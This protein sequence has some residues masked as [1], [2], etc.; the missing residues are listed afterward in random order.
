MRHIAP[1]RVASSHR[2]RIVAVMIGGAI[3]AISLTCVLN[4]AEYVSGIPWPEPKVVNPG[5][6]ADRPATPS[7]CLTAETSRN[8]WAATTGSS[9]TATPSPPST[10]FTP[11]GPSAI[12]NSTS[13]GRPRKSRRRR[14][15]TRQQRR[16][17]DEHDRRVATK[18]KSSI[19][20][21]IAPI[22]TAR[23]RPSTS[24]ARRW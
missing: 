6:A 21:R 11:S 17:H 20:T 19:R 24:N 14:S 15:G 1:Q 22:S 7:C 5:L 3:L 23:P 10:I 18:S 2:R 12:A 13:N 16:V 8:G 9:K 4:A